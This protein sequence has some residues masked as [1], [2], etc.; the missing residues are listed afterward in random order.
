MDQRFALLVL[1]ALGLVSVDTGA[2]WAKP[3]H[4]TFQNMMASSAVIAVARLSP[5]P[6]PVPDVPIVALEFVEVLKGDVKPGIFTVSYVDLPE[7]AKTT[8]EFV[9]FL[10]KDL[11]WRFVAEPI[12]E[13]GLVADGMLRARGFF[14][15]NAYFVTPDL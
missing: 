15:S 14:D 1:V 12:R 3:K 5:T 8:R 11:V 7:L 2:T 10:D 4:T 9:A 13:G 6:P